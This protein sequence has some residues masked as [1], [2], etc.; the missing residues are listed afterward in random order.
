MSADGSFRGRWRKG[1]GF[2]PR[3]VCMLL[4]ILGS[5]S[6]SRGLMDCPPMGEEVLGGWLL[7]G[8]LRGLRDE[9]IV[10]NDHGSLPHQVKNT[11][12]AKLARKYIRIPNCQALHFVHPPCAADDK[13]LRRE[14]LNLCVTL[15]DLSRGCRCWSSFCYRSRAVS[16][17]RYA[18]LRFVGFRS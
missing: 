18:F 14:L 5:W 9:V 2:G 1:A 15:A 8:S 12:P 16:G 10:E 3:G 6:R 13:R 4:F 17:C 11:N 7:W